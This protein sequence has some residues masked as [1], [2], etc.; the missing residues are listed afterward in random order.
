MSKK[1]LFVCLA[2]GVILIFGGCGA[3]NAQNMA[4]K[5]TLVVLKAQKAHIST[6]KYKRHIHHKRAHRF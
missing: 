2:L 4:V 6:K 1:I 3:S 5:E